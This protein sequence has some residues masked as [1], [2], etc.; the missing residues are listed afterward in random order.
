MP[1]CI[2]VEEIFRAETTE[3]EQRGESVFDSLT[4][5]FLGIVSTLS[6]A[7]SDDG[8]PKTGIYP[9]V[10]MLMTVVDDHADMQRHAV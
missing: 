8:I 4:S 6:N 2:P 3:Q 7:E 10:I 1:D 9:A 5:T